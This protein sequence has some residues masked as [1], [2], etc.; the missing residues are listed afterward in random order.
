MYQQATK[1]TIFKLGECFYYF[2]DYKIL[3]YLTNYIFMFA[4]SYIS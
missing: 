3:R 1:A 4:I 2:R